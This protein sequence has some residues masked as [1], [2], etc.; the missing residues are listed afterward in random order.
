MAVLARNTWAAMQGRKALKIT[1]D[2]GP[3]ASYDSA[4]YRATL[5]ESARNAGDGVTINQEVLKNLQEING[6]VNKVSQV[7]Q[8]ISIASDEQLTV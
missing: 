3:N 8:E 1:W 7:M 6:Q 5:E 4:T 2:D